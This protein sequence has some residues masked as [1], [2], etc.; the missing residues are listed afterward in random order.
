MDLENDA[1]PGSRRCTICQQSKPT[2]SF[3]WSRTRQGGSRCAECRIAQNTAYQRRRRADK[4]EVVRASNLWRLYKIRPEEYDALLEAQKHR[5]AIC[6]ILDT[7]VDLSRVGGRPRQNGTLRMVFALA[8]DHHH[9][10]R[11]VRG[12]L[13]PD[14]NRG[15]GHF[16]D[17]SDRLRRAIKYLTALPMAE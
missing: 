9:A 15:L 10:T 14:C 16:K 11:R 1:P 2:K 13:C 17:D 6:Q 4:P 12:L 8:V 5:C 3:G 7:E